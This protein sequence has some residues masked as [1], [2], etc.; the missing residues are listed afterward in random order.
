MD[1][2]T[3]RLVQRVV[4]EQLEVLRIDYLGLEDRRPIGSVQGRPK[5]CNTHV[6][7]NITMN[8]ACNLTFIV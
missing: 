3:G 1:G 8:K 2:R 4:R 5:D 7:Q 6:N